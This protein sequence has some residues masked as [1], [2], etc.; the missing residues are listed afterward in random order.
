MTGNLSF[1]YVPLRVGRINLRLRH[2]S[3]LLPKRKT[4]IWSVKRPFIATVLELIAILEFILNTFCC[5][6]RFNK[7]QR[8]E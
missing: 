8:W 6:A 1:T 5:H 2:G 3:S 4:Q 7:P